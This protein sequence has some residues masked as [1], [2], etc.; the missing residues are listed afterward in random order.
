ME[1]YKGF[2][3]AVGTSMMVYVML[4]LIVKVVS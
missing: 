4:V 3:M 1:T 2:V